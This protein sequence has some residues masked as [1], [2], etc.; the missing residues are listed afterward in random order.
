MTRSVRHTLLLAGFGIALAA[1]AET[2]LVAASP[3]LPP[4]GSAPAGAAENT[5]LE[6][7]GILVDAGGYRFSIYDPVRHTG[8]WVRLDEPGHEFVVKAHDV[9]HDAITLSF[10]GRVMTLPL[11]T[12]KVVGVTVADPGSGPRPT[13]VGLGAGPVPMP[14][15]MSAE[16]SE[17]YNRA[18]EEIARRRAVREQTATPRQN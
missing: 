11:H 8:Q 13:P 7:R 16:E 5:P 2:T 10:Q 17:R 12:A 18:R 3:F 4:G 15:P 14:V 6:L 9:A 1:R